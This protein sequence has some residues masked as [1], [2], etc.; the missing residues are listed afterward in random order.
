MNTRVFIP[1]H[2]F[3]LRKENLNGNTGPP[4][5]PRAM[6]KRV[7]ALENNKPMVFLILEDLDCWKMHF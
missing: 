1:V 3:H 5:F 4:K 6:A 7:R 2:H